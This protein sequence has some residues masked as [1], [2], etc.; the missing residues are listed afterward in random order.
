[1]AENVG[2]DYEYLYNQSLPVLKKIELRSKG[3]RLIIDLKGFSKYHPAIQRMVLRI[4][5]KELKGDTRRLTFKHWKEL[6]D[7]IFR[8]STGSVVDLPRRIKVLKDK[9]RIIISV[10]NA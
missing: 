2:L 8:R 6:E 1:M 5:I 10:R 7:L 3:S 9:R 4:A